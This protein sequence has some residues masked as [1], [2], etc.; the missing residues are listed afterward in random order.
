MTVEEHLNWRY[1][2]ISSYYQATVAKFAPKSPDQK[3]DRHTLKLEDSK[4]L[5]ALAEDQLNLS[6]LEPTDTAARIKFFDL[7]LQVHVLLD[8]INN[9][10]VDPAEGWIR[11]EDLIIDTQLARYYLSASGNLVGLSYK[12]LKYELMA[13]FAESQLL[14]SFKT[15]LIA[16]ET[17]T[18]IQP[19]KHTKDLLSLR[20]H[21]QVLEGTIV[22]EFTFRGGVG[23]HLPNSTTGFS[24]EYWLDDNF[25][26]STPNQLI[27]LQLCFLPPSAEPS[28]TL[29]K[30]LLCVGGVS[31]DSFTL[32]KEIT[33]S[34][35]SQPGGLYGVRFVDGI[36]DFTIDIRT[37]KYLDEAKI[38]PIF[39]PSPLDKSPRFQGS[40][41][42][43][44]KRAEKLLGDEKSINLFYSI[45]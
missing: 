16:T 44:S 33:I 29:F 26:R 15:D 40:V 22:K 20:C 2:E 21:E 13:I 39:T 10:E 37:S 24:V 3:G 32:E 38:T 6:L 4:T 8:A 23:A 27:N 36:S 28:S 42:T 43:L 5:L 41:I 7:V 19:L 11:R 1:Q 14:S 9:P 35:T 25:K 17:P 34:G 45:V 31:E 30:P 18:K 12:S